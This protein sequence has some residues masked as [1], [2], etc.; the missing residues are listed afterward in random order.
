MHAYV[1]H[2]TS[3]VWL[4]PHQ[5]CNKGIVWLISKYTTLFEKGRLQ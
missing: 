4:E 3:K 5:A 2:V 1:E